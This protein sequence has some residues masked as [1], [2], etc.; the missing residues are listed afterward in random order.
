MTATVPSGATTGPVTVTTFTSTLKSNRSFL[1][2]PQITSFTPTSA[3]VGTVVTITGVSLSQTTKVTIGGKNAAFTI[4]SDTQVTATVPAGAKTG[5]KITIT[6]AGGVVNSVANFI[7]LPSITSF[8]PT[9]GPVGTSVAIKGNTFTG[10]TSVK[11]GGVAATSYQVISDT[12]V[13]ALVPTGAIT[14]TI[15]VTTS[16][17]TATSASKFTVTP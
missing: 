13:D 12:E 4:K 16:G 11:F 14:G 1:V 7:V 2:T 5:Q 9:S 3:T 10:T 8:T 15:A 6:T 17:G